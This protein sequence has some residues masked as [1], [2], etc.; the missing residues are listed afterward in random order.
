MFDP[1]LQEFWKER[2]ALEL[3][4]VDQKNA[5]DAERISAKEKEARIAE[6]KG[7]VSEFKVKEQIGSLFNKVKPEAYKKLN[8]SEAFKQKFLNQSK[9]DSFVMAVDIRWSTELMLNARS[10]ADFARFVTDLSSKLMQIIKDDYGVFDK[11]TGDG[12]L[13]FFPE[14][15][16]GPD[17]AY[18]V[19]R[20]ASQCHLA[21]DGLYKASRDSFSPVLKTGLG[22]GID[23]GEVHLVEV[24]G[25][26]TV[27][28]EPVVYAC[29]FSG[30][31][32]GSTLLNQPAYKIVSERFGPFCF[33]RETEIKSKHDEHMNM[34]AYDVK[35]SAKKYSPAVPVW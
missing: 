3:R 33:T 5:L 26:L 11:F 16:T 7:T 31:E 23:F 21:F 17:A 28:G 8:E 13:S 34:L 12:I 14:F 15:Y 10:T 20:A 9:C 19:I 35:L 2:R 18:Y 29:R 25:E 4:V 32:Y 30:G 24:A 22:I 6:L 1:S 27:V